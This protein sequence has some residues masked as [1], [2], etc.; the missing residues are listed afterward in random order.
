MGD[1]LVLNGD[2]FDFWFEY[3]SV[4][5]RS[6]FPTLVALATVRRRGVRLTVTGGNHDRWGGPFWQEELGA[7]FHRGAV[8]LNLAGHPA[9][10]MHGDDLAEPQIRARL[11]RAVVRHPLTEAVFRWVHPDVGWALVQRMSRRL[12]RKT[13]DTAVMQLAAVTQAEYA[14]DLLEQ[15]PELELV[16]LGHTHKPVLEEIGLGRWYVNPGAWMD[17][18]RYATI[19]E[20][21]PE[22]CQFER[23]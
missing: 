20:M 1:H 19:N 21:G 6:A 9:L 11:L 14:H 22:L 23:G 7:S 5:P 18:F 13:V 16:V 17:G 2:L 12:A 10:V 8:E 4:I 3:R 15:R